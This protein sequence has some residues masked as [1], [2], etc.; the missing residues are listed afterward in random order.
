MNSK[1]KLKILSLLLALCMVVCSLP[2]T[3]FAAHENTHKNTDDA[4]SDI[5]KIAATQIG[6]KEEENGYTKYGASYGNET[7]DCCCACVAWCAL[8][9]EISVNTIPQEIGSTAMQNAFI[10]KKLYMTIGKLTIQA[11]KEVINTFEK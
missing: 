11:T 5:L 4:L 10:S 9:A 3:A 8:Q 2:I 1:R 6:Y 7:M